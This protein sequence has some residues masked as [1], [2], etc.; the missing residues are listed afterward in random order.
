VREKVEIS[1]GLDA[2]REPKML[3]ETTSALCH[4]LCS[5]VA[6]CH[7]EQLYSMY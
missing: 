6:T 2:M 5:Q 3:P 1:C 4:S 7:N